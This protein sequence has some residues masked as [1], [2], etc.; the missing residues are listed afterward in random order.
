[1]I[2]LMAEKLTWYQ[3]KIVVDNMAIKKKIASKAKV[4]TKNDNQKKVKKS[5]VIAKKTENLAKLSEI[6]LTASEI[7]S[8]T[9]E[10]TI[11]E[12]NYILVVD[13]N[14]SMSAHQDPDEGN[15]RFALEIFTDSG[16]LIDVHSQQSYQTYQD[17]LF[18]CYG[19]IEYLGFGITD[20]NNCANVTVNHWNEEE[21]KYDEDIILFD[22]SDFF[23]KK[24]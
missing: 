8:E 1:M 6:I 10:I 11:S 14:C 24:K 20:P 4:K 3:L 9:N 16:K 22:G 18:D 13:Y 15:W 17:A 5:K 2:L 21:E 12:E 7:D 23:K 19:I